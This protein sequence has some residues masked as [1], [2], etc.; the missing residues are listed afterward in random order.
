[1]KYK[2][3]PDI[4]SLMRIQI[5]VQAFS[6]RG[7]YGEITRIAN[8]YKISRLFV[9]QLLGQLLGLFQPDNKE[10]VSRQ[11]AQ[12]RLDQH[13]LLLRLEGKCSLEAISQILTELGFAHSSIG[14]ISQ[15]ILEFAGALPVELPS[16][17]KIEFYL[18]D[19]T[20]AN[21][22]PIL[23]TVDPQSL[24]ILRIELA[25]SRDAETWQAHWQALTAL[26]YQDSKY[27][28][29]DLGKGIVKGCGLMGLTHHPDLF[30]LLQAIAIFFSRFERQAYAAI[31]EEA[32]RMKVFEQAKSERVLREKL[33]LYEQAQSKAATAIALFDDFDYLWQQLKTSFDL[34]DRQGNFKDPA[35]NLTDLL[36]IIELLKKLNCEHL[37]KELVSFEKALPAYWD[38]FYRAKD[39]YQEM[40]NSYGSE[41]VTLVALAWQ[42]LRQATNSKNYPV[43]LYL[44]GEAQH[45]LDWAESISS[46]AFAEM[47]ATIFAAFNANIRASSLVENIN[48]GLRKL[49]N[50]CRGQ[51]TQAF[52]NLFA[53][54]HNHRPFLR[55]VRKGSAP[56]EILTGKPLEKSWIDALLDSAF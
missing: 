22:Q 30:H 14:Y 42:Y 53:Y 2:R 7:I 9:Y 13:I 29:S 37:T 54:V 50:N 8:Q 41:L 51:V 3:R 38:Y 36:A 23:V 11:V 24:A 19:E 35:T 1:M 48:S 18:S 26:G 5:A 52:L 45:Y 21:G 47:K 15:R 31:G 28:V 12:R 32:A 43:K 44:T 10:V 4:N 46:I 49:L 6:G 39:I 16:S 25:T 55:G 56:I 17:A 40:V 33:A 34:F 20:F 27:V